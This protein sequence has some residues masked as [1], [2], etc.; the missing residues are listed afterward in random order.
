MKNLSKKKRLLFTSIL[1]VALVF[2]NLSS[3]IIPIVYDDSSNKVGNENDHKD[4]INKIGD[5]GAAGYSDSQEGSGADIDILLHQSIVDYE[6]GDPIHEIADFDSIANRSFEIDSPSDTSFNSSYTEIKV[7]D[8]YAPNKTLNLELGTTGNPTLSTFYWAFSFEVYSECVLENFSICFSET[9]G[10]TIDGKVEIRLYNA[11]DTGTQIEPLSNTNLITISQLIN[12]QDSR[13]WYN[14]TDLYVPLD[15]STT[16]E[17][18]FFIV[19]W[20]NSDPGPVT[21]FHTEPDSGGDNSIVHRKS[22]T[23]PWVKQDT[24]ISSTVK[25]GLNNNKPT[26]EDIV[27]E[28]N[29]TKVSNGIENSGTWTNTSALPSSNSQLNFTLDAGWWDVECNITRIQVNYTK[30]DLFGITDFTLIKNAANA[31]W[32]CNVSDVIDSFD[33][34]FENFYMNFTIPATWSVEGVYNGTSDKKTVDIYGPIINGYQN[35]TV[36][37]AGNGTNWFLN[38]TSNNLLQSIKSKVGIDETYQVHYLDDVDLQANFSEVI[39]DGEVNLTIYN[40][41]TKFS[42]YTQVNTST[43]DSIILFPRWNISDTGNLDYGKFIMQAFWS[44][45]TA[46]AF[47]EQPLTVLAN[48]ELLLISPSNNSFYKS[49]FSEFNI[50]VFFNDTGKPEAITTDDVKFQNQSI[51]GDLTPNGTTGYYNLTINPA[52]FGY[53]LNTIKINASKT[54]YDNGTIYYKFHKIINS[55]ISSDNSSSFEIT[56]GDTIFYAFN[57]TTDPDEDPIQGAEIKLILDEGTFDWTPEEIG[58]PGSYRIKLNSTYVT[59]QSGAYD[60]IFNISAPGNET[61]VISLQI[62]VL[63]PNT[64]VDLETDISDFQIPI[65]FNITLKFNFT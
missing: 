34:K 43:S 59:A 13:V 16:D 24:D 15:P 32:Q 65:G 46:A 1:L 12:D 28:I 35:I 17:N 44:N 51:V 38:A 53:G 61:Q 5:F 58:D 45:D 19:F 27:M 33:S 25:V 14:F 62:T 47:W 42:N 26:P 39:N 21:E 56:R 40:D 8:I 2:V 31:T 7:E 36:L 52:D 48:T 20:D 55:T 60:F 4:P 41:E 9:S 6:N 54:Y 64:K 18:T 50:T 10:G 30:T 63:K 29:G 11:D 23:N 49:P 57:Y 3:G 37:E 22:G